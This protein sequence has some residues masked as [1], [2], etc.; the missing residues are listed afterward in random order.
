M[1]RRGGRGRGHRARHSL[2]RTGDPMT[3]DEDVDSSEMGGEIISV[4]PAVRGRRGG[5]RT[6][7]LYSVS[8]PH[9]Q[10]GR[11]NRRR[12]RP[13][14]TDTV[15]VFPL[16]ALQS[17]IRDV[18]SVL[19]PESARPSVSEKQWTARADVQIM[20]CRTG[21]GEVE[22]RHCIDELPAGRRRTCS[23]WAPDDIST[24]GASSS[25]R[26]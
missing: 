15:P 18:A 4:M 9:N 1:R 10:R 19:P 22:I 5:E 11:C 23:L 6:F 12:G 8:I 14:R 13:A 20:E 3:D 2:S 26:N 24:C 25:G 16:G 7:L 17:M 21:R